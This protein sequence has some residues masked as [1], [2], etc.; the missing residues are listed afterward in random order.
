MNCYEHREANLAYELF[1]RQIWHQLIHTKCRDKG[2]I[3]VV[4]FSDE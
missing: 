4:S 3:C 1:F 2:F